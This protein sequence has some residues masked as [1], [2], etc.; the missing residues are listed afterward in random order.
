MWIRLPCGQQ[1]E[2]NDKDYPSTSRDPGGVRIY[3]PYQRF[4]S[5]IEITLIPKAKAKT[6]FPILK[7]S[8]KAVQ[9]TRVVYTD[10]GWSLQKVLRT[11]KFKCVYSL[12][13]LRVL[14]IVSARTYDNEYVVLTSRL[15]T[16]SGA[17]PYRHSPTPK[18]SYTMRLV[19]A[20]TCRLTRTRSQVIMRKVWTNLIPRL[21]KDF[22]QTTS[23]FLS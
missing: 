8:A 11:Y 6:T 15:I 4:I 12:K 2:Y 13:C 17:M 14:I 16:K 20:S 1:T 21:T 18:T 19:E 5:S 7:T 10:Y 9:T 22:F 3:N 23:C